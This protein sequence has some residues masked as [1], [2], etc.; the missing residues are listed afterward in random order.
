[1]IHC[2]SISYIRVCQ[3]AKHILT[4]LVTIMRSRKRHVA[5]RDISFSIEM[6]TVARKPVVSCEVALAISSRRSANGSTR[7][8]TSDESTC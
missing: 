7:S 5:Y 1:M 6:Y 8:F 2:S 4:I 3:T